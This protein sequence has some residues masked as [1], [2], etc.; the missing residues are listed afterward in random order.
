VNLTLWWSPSRKDFKTCGSDE[1]AAD[2]GPDY[3]A[4]GTQCFALNG[5]G[6]ANLPCKFGGNSIARG[7]AAFY[8]NDCEG[9]R[10]SGAD[11]GE[12]ERAS[13]AARA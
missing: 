9:V 11:E 8:D 7:D 4:R 1:C 12:V 10:A 6:P 5:V 3:V 2:T 13:R